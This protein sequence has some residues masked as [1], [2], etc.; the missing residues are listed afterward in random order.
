VQ[1]PSYSL[2]RLCANP[3]VLFENKMAA[4]TDHRRRRL[5]EMGSA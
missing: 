2:L 4:V 5:R 1:Q 3:F